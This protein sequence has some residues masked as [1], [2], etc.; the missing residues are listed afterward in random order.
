M[1]TTVKM[2]QISSSE[3]QKPHNVKIQ[4]QNL[5][6]SFMEINALSAWKKSNGK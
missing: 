6:G 5:C 3:T 2:A 1:A 4:T